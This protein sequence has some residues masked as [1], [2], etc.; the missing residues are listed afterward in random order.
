[1]EGFIPNRVHI[2]N[3][4]HELKGVQR[5]PT[6][7]IKGLDLCDGRVQA[8]GQSQSEAWRVDRDEHTAMFGQRTE[9]STTNSYHANWK[10]KSGAPEANCDGVGG[11]RSHG[12]GRGCMRSKGPQNKSEALLNAPMACLSFHM[13]IEGSGRLRG[14]GAASGPQCFHRTGAGLWCTPN[15]K[16][17]TSD[18]S[19]E[20]PQ[21]ACVKS[22]SY[23]TAAGPS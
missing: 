6:R 8:G 7:A 2:N 22:L 4:K 11:L 5:L 3:S 9:E 12:M 16:P 1:M 13:E 19:P 23:H 18:S 20:V 21:T 14:S 17:T 15:S 10:Q